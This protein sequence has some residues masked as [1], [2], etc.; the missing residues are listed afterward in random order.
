MKTESQ[1]NHKN[2]ISD[3]EQ[4]KS[5]VSVVPIL[6]GSYACYQLLKDTKYDVTSIYHLT[7]KNL[8]HRYQEP[9]FRFN[10]EQFIVAE[11]WVTIPV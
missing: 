11:L 6:L 9:L 8:P 2:S 3:V 4:N 7:K 5:S 10:N 1:P